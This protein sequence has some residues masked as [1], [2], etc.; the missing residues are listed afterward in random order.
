MRVAII[1]ISNRV[2]FLDYISCFYD[3]NENQDEILRYL[4]NQKSAVFISDI[5]ELFSG[6]DK[7]QDSSFGIMII[8]DKSQVMDIEQD[9]YKMVN[10]DIKRMIK[11]QNIIVNQRLRQSRR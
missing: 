4:M 2:Y 6:D 11:Q 5:F 8:D 3:I 10:T 7:K 9:S 1:S